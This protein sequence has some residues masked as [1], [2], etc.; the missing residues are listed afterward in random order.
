MLK[1]L[2]RGVLGFSFAIS[3]FQLVFAE[4]VQTTLT[5]VADLPNIGILAQSPES[6]RGGLLQVGN[7]LW[8]TTYAGGENSI[9]AIVSYSLETGQFTTQHSFGLPNPSEPTQAR[10]DG[11]AP[12]KTTL[13]MGDDN[14][15]YYATQY[16]G[17]SWTSGSN[18]GAIGSFDPA[19][20]STTGV[21]VV[22]SG[23][24]ASNQPR[25]LG[26]AS[27]IYVPNSG[28]GASIYFNTYAGGA[29]D[30]GSIQKVTLDASGNPTGS[31]QLTEFVGSLSTPNSGRQPQ[32]GMLLVGNKIYYTTASTATES[33]T[34]VVANATLQVIDTST[35]QVSVLSTT[36]FTGGSSTGGWNTP[37]YDA[38]RNSIYSVALSGGI[39]KFDLTDGLADPQSLLPNS[40]DGGAGNFADPI[41][42]G[43]SIY[44]V[45]Q[46]SGSSTAANYGGQI[47]RYDLDSEY[48][49]LLYNLKDYDGVSSNQSGSFSVVVEDGKE[50]LYFLTASDRTTGTTDA[51]GALYRLEV[52]AVPEP[53][54]VG[55]LLLGLGLCGRHLYR[56]R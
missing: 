26:Y 40:N 32:G 41:I 22:W 39:L 42:F 13:T 8:F 19:T 48:I 31:T 11:F 34:G 6:P 37:L 52:I 30:W 28:G 38:E 46:A 49:E 1:N 17:A 55:L 10:Y 35:D 36:W 21:K 2:R 54:V 25:N 43:D 7:D 3:S 9:G 27:P 56:R 24:V 47:W 29:K 33:S 18:G 16:G 20:I 4:Q 15:V 23:A 44:Y 50:V 5:K 14:R 45:K 51:F 12:W 53:G